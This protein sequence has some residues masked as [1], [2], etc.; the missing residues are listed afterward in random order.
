MKSMKTSRNNSSQLTTIKGFEERKMK[1]LNITKNVNK[2]IRCS[3]FV[4]WLCQLM[5][6]FLLRAKRERLTNIN[7]VDFSYYWKR[8]KSFVS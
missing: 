5:R 8:A 6:P 7:F 2:T 1:N 4:T 3:D